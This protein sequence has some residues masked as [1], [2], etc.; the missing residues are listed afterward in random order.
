MLR[1]LGAEIRLRVLRLLL[2]AHRDGL[3][4]SDIQS[5]PGIPRFEVFPHHLEK[6]KDDPLR[7][8]RLKARGFAWYTA[9]VEALKI[10]VHFL[11]D[12]YC[13]RS[14]VIKSEFLI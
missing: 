2:S 13:S 14:K 9:N 12:K 7:S 10:L 5:T 4:K 1:A 11:C 6:L 3:V 8:D